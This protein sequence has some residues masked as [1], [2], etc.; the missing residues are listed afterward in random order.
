[1]SAGP[2]MNSSRP[3]LL[4]AIY[5]WIVDNGCTPYLLVDAECP[6]LE[7]PPQ[8]VKDGKVVLNLAPQAVSGMEMGDEEIV[9]LTRFGGV[10]MRVRVPMQATQA[11]YAQEN[12]QGMLFQDETGHA[13][14]A[15][16][17][18]SDSGQDGAFGNDGDDGNGS[19]GDKPQRGAPHLRVIK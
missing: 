9:F 5:Q 13:A 11:V 2:S 15:P 18:A 14:A 4:R 6:G 3:Y 16:A 17:S 8:A 7:V 10:S 1:M 19:P 12:G